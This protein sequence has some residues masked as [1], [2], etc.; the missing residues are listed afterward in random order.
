MAAPSM[1]RH[2]Q[3]DLTEFLARRF[4]EALGIGLCLISLVLAVAL[5]G[6]DPGDPSLNHATSGPSSNPL[7]GFGATLADLCLQTVGTAIWFAVLV[8]P[9]WGLAA[10]FGPGS[11]L[12]L[13]F[14][15]GFAAGGPGAFRLSRDAGRTADRGLALSRRSRRRGRRF[16]VA[17]P[18]AG[19][20]CALWAL[21]SGLDVGSGGDR[22]RYYAGRADRRHSQ[23]ARSD[24]AVRA[25]QQC[26]AQSACPKLQDPGAPAG[27]GWA[28]NYG[29]CFRRDGCSVCRPVRS[30]LIQAG[31]G[32]GRSLRHHEESPSFVE[33][34]ART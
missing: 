21:F 34:R 8:L 11:E 12:D 10:D 17:P 20:W 33:N 18:G 7:G 32:R 30:A 15:R 5:W 6:Y 29:P 22:H 14:G 27:S 31:C 26:T 13:A 25:R 2:G 28:W 16:R 19:A 24:D 3:F 1:S 23:Y 9:I 4:S